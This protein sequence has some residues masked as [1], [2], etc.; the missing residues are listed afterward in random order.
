MKIFELISPQ[1]VFNVGG[2]SNLDFFIAQSGCPE[3][4]QN[5]IN[6][7]CTPY[8]TFVKQQHY[9]YSRLFAYQGKYKFINQEYNYNKFRGHYDVIWDQIPSLN[10][11]VGQN[12]NYIN[13]CQT[14]ILTHYHNAIGKHLI[15][16]VAK[17]KP[18]RIVSHSFCV[19]DQNTLHKKLCNNIDT[20]NLRIYNFKDY[21]CID[22]ASSFNHRVH[23]HLEGL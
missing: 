14:F 11:F 5:T 2:F 7:D 9:V 13:S 3:K 18:L 4:V 15:N 6:I 10:G 12:E 8:K 22:P 16:T 23:S 21:V 20:H 19:F 17:V 1:T